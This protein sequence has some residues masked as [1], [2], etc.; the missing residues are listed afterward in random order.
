M[1]THT[2]PIALT[3]QGRGVVGIER[4]NLITTGVAE[5]VIERK[6]I[7]YWGR[8]T[9]TGYVWTETIIEMTIDD[10]MVYFLVIRLGTRVY[11]VRTAAEIPIRDVPGFITY[12]IATVAA[13][14]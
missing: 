7:E 13:R 14:G 11:R 3:D 9:I 6:G 12:P 4:E 10:P 2:I 5:R 8:H 1:T